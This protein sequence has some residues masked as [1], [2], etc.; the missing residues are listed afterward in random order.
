V[1][2]D[3]T[4]EPETFL[5]FL[6]DKQLVLSHLL[7]THAHFDHAMGAAEVAAVTG[8]TPRLHPGDWPL[9]EHIP[10]MARRFGL[11]LEPQEVPL[12]ELSDGEILEVEPGFRLQVSH[13]P[14]HTPGHVTFYVAELDLAVVGDTLFMGSVGR[15]DLPGGDSAT[16]VRA[17][18]EKLYVLPD[19]TRVIPGHGPATTIG[20]EKRENPFVRA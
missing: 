3:P 15:T 20:R 12:V 4:D 17:I 9:F 11:E 8:C 10:Q 13:C 19:G 1:L 7:L 14:G 18:K 16:L 2:I 6:A 5:E